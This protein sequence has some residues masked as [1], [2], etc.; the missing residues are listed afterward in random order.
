MGGVSRAPYI[1]LPP[2]ESKEPGGRGEAAPGIFDGPLATQRDEVLRAL[3]ETLRAASPERVARVLNVRG[4]NLER[5]EET[6]RQLLA[7]T[8][9]LLPAWQRFDGVVW[10]HLDPASLREGQ[11]RRLLVPSGVYGLSSGTDQIADFRLT[12]KVSL[13]GLGNLATFWRTALT[14]QLESL[15]PAQL[16]SV[17]PKEHAAAIGASEILSRRL[18]TVSFLHHDG[19][20]VAG[21]DAKA[22]KGVVARR[23][24]QEGLNAVE[25]F[26]WRGWRGRVHRGEYLV[27]APRATTR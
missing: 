6:T 9:P 19:Q 2:S 26:E 13:D 18:V 10:K 25:G 22:V 27:R 11:R 8:A 16:V 1:L 15:A 24:V 5:A 3:R 14:A 21:H 20:G 17:L 4:Q 23:I 12:M 7:G